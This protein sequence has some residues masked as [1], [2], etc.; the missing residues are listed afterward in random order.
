MSQRTLE[1]RERAG[2]LVAEGRK[3]REIVEADE[4][5]STLTD[6][7][8]TQ[9]NAL[10]DEAEQLIDD[11][12][13]LERQET[14]EARAGQ[15]QEETSRQ[16]QDEEQAD[17]GQ[18]QGILGFTRT[19]QYADA[20]EA[21][22]RGGATREQ[23]QLVQEAI[24][25]EAR[26]TLQVDQDI[27][28]GFLVA[29]ERF[30]AQLLVAADNVNV[31]R[32]FATKFTT[33]FAE[34]LGVPTLDSDLTAFAYGA[35][36]LTEA[37]ED[38]GLAFG[39]RELKARP[40]LRKVV[41]ASRQLLRS[42]QM[43]VEAIIT[44]RAGVALGNGQE[45]GFMTG[46][47]A[48]QPLGL[49]TASDDGIPTG[50]DVSTGNTN[51]TI[52]GD[53]LIEVQGTLADQYDDAARWLFH[54][55]AITQIRQLKDG[56]QQ[57]IW[58]AGLAEREPNTI[59]GKPYMTGSSV[60]NTFTSALYVG[61]YGVFS[62]YWIVDAGGMIVQRLEEKYTLTGQVGFLFDN[63]ASDGMPVLPDAFVRIKL[64]A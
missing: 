11:A 15:E 25:P 37:S 19:A 34:S 59:L 48:E 44:Q 13:R 54:K 38:T 22:L 26:A 1:M 31:V 50:R 21:F 18:N 39:K 12:G 60:P 3:I 9:F 6:D 53:N 10:H 36:E 30:L 33:D 46:N 47:G 49:F 2:G 5:R 56:N 61:M 17:A 23:G 52:Q 24:S 32:S 58:R 28:G 35:G 64:A 40:M 42:P 8:T 51:T 62:W 4:A 27:G 29:S 63:V 16:T 43:N 57:Y 20:F 45:T 7:E 55:G 41:K 14:L